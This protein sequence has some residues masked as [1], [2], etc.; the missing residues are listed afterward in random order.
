MK[1]RIKKVM[2]KSGLSA[3]KFADKIGVPR[4]GLSHVLS[5]RNKPS[6]DY[7][8]KMLNAFP[9]LDPYWLLKGQKSKTL[10]TKSGLDNSIEEFTLPKDLNSSLSSVNK[11]MGSQADQMVE[12]ITKEPIESNSEPSGRLSDKDRSNVNNVDRI[13]YFYND[14]SFKEYFPSK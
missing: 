3:S 9:E 12:K 1:D 11:R 2:D 13:V 6:L 7:V 14:G 10:D 4:S 8:L 5:G